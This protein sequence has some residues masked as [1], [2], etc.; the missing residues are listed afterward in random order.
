MKI[1]HCISSASI[2]G[3]ER[4]VIE[5]AVAQKEAGI[6][7]AIMLDQKKGLYLKQLEENKIYAGSPVKEIGKR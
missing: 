2:G 7:V 5:L 4:L 1:L 3:I 6:E